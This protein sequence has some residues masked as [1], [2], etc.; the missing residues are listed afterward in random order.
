LYVLVNIK[1]INERRR[2]RTSYENKKE[3]LRRTERESVESIIREREK[4]RV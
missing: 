1:R 3:R 2:R 4:E